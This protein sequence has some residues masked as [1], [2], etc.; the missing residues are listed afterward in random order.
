MAGLTTSDQMVIKSH[1]INLNGKNMSLKYS[2]LMFVVTSLLAGCAVG[3]DY[4][5]PELSTPQHFFGQSSL[6]KQETIN[7]TNLQAWWERFGDEQLTRYIST[8]LQQN[9]DLTQAAPRVTQAQ[10]GLGAANAALLPA[11]YISGQ[12]ARAYQSIETPLGQVLNSSPGFD[13]Y[14]NR[15][16][17][18]LSASWELDLFG[19]L[20]RDREIA[21]AEYQATSAGVAA[22]RLAVT[23]QTANIYI[24][25]RA[26]QT[27]LNIARKQVATQQEML[28][29]LN[30][31][32]NKGLIAER[33]V[34]QAQASLAQT[35]SFVPAL[36][37]SLEAAMNALDVILGTTPG[38]HRAELATLAPIPT[39]PTITEMVAIPAHRITS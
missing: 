38:T 6:G 26:L 8:A 21:L 16:E 17:A 37:A 27:R 9:L 22:T 24:N 18:N 20:R 5:S 13:R 30:L 19:G 29:L 11:G 35:Q 36:E 39:T 1:Q 31:L 34:Q 10:A 7:N 32:Y 25:I 28:A 15:Y 33:Q 4:S 23:A 2:S 3:P 12:A 14:G